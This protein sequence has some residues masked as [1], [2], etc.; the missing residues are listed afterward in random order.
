MRLIL[1]LE[2]GV[3]QAPKFEESVLV[4]GISLLVV[5][6]CCELVDMLPVW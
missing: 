6:L 4:A 3:T 2:G 5:A 1:E